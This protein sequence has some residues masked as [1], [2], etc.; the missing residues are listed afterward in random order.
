M[1]LANKQGK[2]WNSDYQAGLS[3]ATDAPQCR[4]KILLHLHPWN[5]PKESSAEHVI[6]RDTLQAG[7]YGQVGLAKAASTP[8]WSSHSPCVLAAPRCPRSTKIYSTLLQPVF[9]SLLE[10]QRSACF[11]G[12]VFCFII[13]TLEFLATYLISSIFTNKDKTKTQ[14]GSFLVLFPHECLWGEVQPAIC[15]NQGQ[16]GWQKMNGRT[17]EQT[18]KSLQVEFS[19]S[20]G[21]NRRWGDQLFWVL[22]HG[23]AGAPSAELNQPPAWDD[24]WWTRWASWA[25]WPNVTGTLPAGLPITF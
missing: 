6:P 21:S 7:S 16:H 8:A 24:P 17:S 12:R 2:Q 11:A 19:A 5:T 3:R 22:A 10:P 14:A 13:L 18:L 23:E 1:K 25:T 4:E 9:P 20:L 15:W